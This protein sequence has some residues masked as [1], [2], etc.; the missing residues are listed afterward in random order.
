MINKIVYRW[1]FFLRPEKCILAMWKKENKSNS[2]NCERLMETLA[3]LMNTTVVNMN[4][5]VDDI[6]VEEVQLFDSI[7]GTHLY[8]K[9]FIADVPEQKVTFKLNVALKIF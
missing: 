4:K 5:C 1:K 3:K 9:E 7:K 6:E 8:I 2:L